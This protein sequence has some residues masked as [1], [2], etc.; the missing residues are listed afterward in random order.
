MATVLGLNIKFAANT[1]GISKGA[2]QTAKQLNGI[3]KSAASAT[4][5]LR[6]LVGIELAKMFAS[7]TSAITGYIG[8]VRESAGA[9]QTL[10]QISN[11]SVEEFQRYAAAAGTVGIESDKLADI[12]KDVN[13]RVGDFLQTG[14]GPMADFFE[15][16]APKVG[17]TAEQFAAL[18]GPEAL[19]LYVKS[20]QDANL[21]QQE[22]TFYLE[23]MASDTT[24]LIPLLANGGEAFGNLADRAERLGIVLSEDQAGAIK[25]MNGALSLVSQTFEGIIGQ[26]TANLAPIVTAITEE[27]L[28]F[29]EAFQGFGGEGGSGIA[30]ALTEGLLDFAEYMATIFDG[31][32]EQ[33]GS[34]GETMATVSG[35][36]E[37]VAN[38]F[39]AVTE[40]LRGIFN[41]FEMFGNALMV[42]L[43]KVLEGLGSWVSSDLEQVGKS[44]AQNA[45]A[46]FKKNGQEAG[47][48]FVN[49]ANAALGDRNFGRQ[50]G[51]GGFLAETVRSARER[52]A[53]RGTAAASAPAVREAVSQ[54]KKAEEQRLKDIQRLN[55]DYAKASK[56]IE[57]ERLDSLAE[58][59]RKALEATDVRS[60]GIANVIALATGREDP[61]VAEARKQVRKLDEIRNELRNLGGTVELVGAA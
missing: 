15:N 2:Q 5:A 53:G 28:S 54:Q 30:N 24:A 12:F 40:T 23:A 49:A 38:T 22:M 26:V 47:N 17:V 13:D 3:S 20:L 9:L 43:G 34:F 6:G 44:I 59:T 19:Q 35:I 18:S 7:A 45:S 61:A 55:E 36:F 52:F 41:L 14:G 48:A 57:Q 31:V 37:F 46:E 51:G 50:Q 4:S 33:F 60:G 32:I 27:F 16:I 39:V 58:N 21:S 42:G 11:A 25:E 56:D 29:V 10:S 8:S 1:S